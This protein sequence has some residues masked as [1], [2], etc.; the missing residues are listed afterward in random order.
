MLFQYPAAI[1]SYSNPHRASIEPQKG[2]LTKQGDRIFKMFGTGLFFLISLFFAVPAF[3]ADVTLAWDPNSEADLEGYGV[4]Y[5]KGAPGPPFDLFGYVTP[6]EF[7]DPSN[8]TFTVTGLEKGAKYYF[9]LT[10]YDSVGTESN[11]SDAVCA[12]VGE[13]IAPCSTEDPVGGGSSDGGSSSTGGGSSDGGGGSNNGCFI[14]T[15][16]ADG[17]S[18]GPGMAAPIALAC[19]AAFIRIAQRHLKRFWLFCKIRTR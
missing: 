9:V 16:S 7:S 1:S 19:L 4:Y 8:P 11:F 3:A 13:I 18:F 6:E 17:G 5:K 15:L 10:A 2:Q 14:D 12:D